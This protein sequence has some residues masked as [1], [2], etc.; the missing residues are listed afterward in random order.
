M[1]KYH[2]YFTQDLEPPCVSSNGA[3]QEAWRELRYLDVLADNM[4]LEMG[5]TAAK[6]GVTESKDLRQNIC[7]LIEFEYSETFGRAREIMLEENERR[8]RAYRSQVRGDFYHAQMG[9]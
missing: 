7:E 1:T 8:D 4:V 6:L 3:S 9:V 2:D 5:R